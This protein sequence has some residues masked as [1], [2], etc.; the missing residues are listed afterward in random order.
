LIGSISVEDLFQNTIAFIVVAII[1]TLPATARITPEAASRPELSDQI[2]SEAVGVTGPFTKF[3]GVVVPRRNL[4]IVYED[5]I[6]NES[7]LP[8]ALVAKLIIEND[9]KPSYNTAIAGPEAPL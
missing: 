2:T 4:N 5:L 1:S 7:P 9:D 8:K 3:I 6:E